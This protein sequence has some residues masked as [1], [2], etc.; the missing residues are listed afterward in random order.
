MFLWCI[1]LATIRW[2]HQAYDLRVIATEW[3]KYVSNILD[4]SYLRL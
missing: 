1:T 4:I 2:S 3:G